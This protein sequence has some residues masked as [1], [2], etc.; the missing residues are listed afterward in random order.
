[1]SYIA[2]QLLGTG[3]EAISEPRLKILR[4]Q[5]KEGAME[6]IQKESAQTAQGPLQPDAPSTMHSALSHYKAELQAAIDSYRDN[7][8]HL[9]M[10]SPTSDPWPDLS[11]HYNEL[12]GISSPIISGLACLITHLGGKEMSNHE[13]NSVTQQAKV[14]AL[15]LHAAAMPLTALPLHPDVTTNNLATKNGPPQKA[16]RD[17]MFPPDKPKSSLKAGKFF[18]DHSSTPPPRQKESTKTNLDNDE[19][20]PGIYSRT[21]DG[22]GDRMHLLIA[23]FIKMNDKIRDQLLKNFM[24]FSELMH[25]NMDGLQIHPLSTEKSLPILTSPK[26]KNI[27]TT[28]NKVGDYFYIQNNFSLIPG[29]RNKSKAPPQ[30]V[31]ANGRFQFDKNR[32]YNGPDRITGVMS[33]SAPGNVKQAI[34]DLLIELKG[35]THQIKYKPTQ[36]KNSKAEKM[37]PGVPTGLCGKGIM[38][39]IRHGLKSCEKTLCNAKKFTIKANMDWYQLPLPVMNG[40]F[41][42]VTPP[43]AISN[44]ESGKYLL[45]KVTEFK[46]NG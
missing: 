39:S 46:K 43:K 42:Q 9:L 14:D 34:G 7:I 12:R 1:M 21:I 30:K 38:R 15:G 45:N 40:Y 17:S 4:N 29:T 11:I 3:G 31:D 24:Y 41:K 27:P 28:G 13:I 44:L 5:A 35:D 33:V 16:P 36:C 26:D 20:D 37:F 22:A 2:L 8:F 18:P 23:S 19:D 32:Q 25:A 10:S 6:F